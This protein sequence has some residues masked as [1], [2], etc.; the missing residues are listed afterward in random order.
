MK[1]QTTRFGEIEV[2]EERVLRFQAGLL[3]FPGLTRY[4]LLDTNPQSPFKWLQCLDRPDLA[5]VVM[6]PRVVKPDYTAVLRPHDVAD[7]E[8]RDEQQ[9]L[10]LVLVT[11]PEGDPRRMTANLLGPLVINLAN[12]R[13]KQV[14]L[15]EGEYSSRHPLIPQPSGAS[16]CAGSTAS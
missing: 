6:D 1:V 13:G 2:P 8:I 3:G 12:G 7:L 16:P 14:V 10:L 11:V 15:V 5:F 4:V 9:V